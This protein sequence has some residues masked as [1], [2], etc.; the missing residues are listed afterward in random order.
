MQITYIRFYYNPLTGVLYQLLKTKSR[1]SI[2]RAGCLHSTGY[3]YVEMCG[4]SFAETRIIWWIMTGRK[5]LPLCEIDHKDRVRDNNVWTNLRQVNRRANVKNRRIFRNSVSQK[6]GVCY[7]KNTDRWQAYISAPEKGK[8]GKHHIGTF[9][10][11]DE[12]VAAVAAHKLSPN[13]S[14]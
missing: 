2:R 10:T 11:C 7:V 9:R 8:G 4:K 5:A 1:K 13:F 12:A 3:R 6:T 14:E